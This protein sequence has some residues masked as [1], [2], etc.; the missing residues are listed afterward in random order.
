MNVTM[1]QLCAAFF[2]LHASCFISCSDWRDGIAPDEPQ[3]AITFTTTVVSSQAATRADGSLINR[4]E[5]RLFP[6]T[7]RSYWVIGE[8]GELTEKKATYSVGLIGYNTGNDNA[9]EITKNASKD[10][11]SVQLDPDF[12]FNQKADIGDD[13]QSLTYSPLRFWPNNKDATTGN[14]NEYLHFWAYYPW[15]ESS[16]TGTYGIGINK[17]LLKENKVKFTMH[18]DASEQS[19]F[20]MSDFV[21]DCNRESNPLQSDG[22]PKPVRLRMH[23]LL[24]QVRIYAFVRGADKMVYKQENG[25]DKVADKEW[26]EGQSVGDIITDPYGNVYTK[27]S[28][29]NVAQTTTGKKDLTPDEFEALGLRVP[30]ESKCVRWDRE[31]GTWDVT[32]SRRRANITYSLAFNNIYTST[33]FTTVYYPSEKTTTVSHDEEGASLGSAT[34]NHYIMNPYWFR[35]DSNGERYQLNDTYMYDYFEDTPGYKGEKS[36]DNIDGI[37]WSTYGGGNAMNYELN[38]ENEDPDNY[39]EHKGQHF[40][41]AP[42]NILLVV[43]QQLND[44]DVPHVVITA[45]GYRWVWKKDGAIV[46]EG[47]EG[48]VKEK[49][50]MPELS[51]KVTV[52]MLNMNLKWESGFIYCYAFIDDDMKPGDDKVKGPESITVVFDPTKHTDQW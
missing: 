6:S 51:G 1:K 45:T 14:Y 15:N 26:L 42:G 2:M 48:A 30:D 27:K 33:T 49:E 43:P 25:K 52:N 11:A 35:F 36:D 3:Q 7:E 44:D 40:N 31:G 12:M 32:H 34:V 10:P 41:Y 23:H 18:P 29:G 16:S 22:T 50:P 5:T 13:G 8:D 38:P 37:D 46:S 28:D 19:D 21:A 17:D 39:R 47:T 20:L 24:A 4:E 9:A